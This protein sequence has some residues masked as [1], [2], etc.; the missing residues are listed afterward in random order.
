MHALA[1]SELHAAPCLPALPPSC[2]CLLTQL[3]HQ[4]THRTTASSRHCAL[5]P[6]MTGVRPCSLPPM[7][8]LRRSPRPPPCTRWISAPIQAH[9]PL[10]NSLPAPPP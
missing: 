4:L 9:A 2:R 3:T 5:F 8:H 7:P 10:R 1:R 6:G